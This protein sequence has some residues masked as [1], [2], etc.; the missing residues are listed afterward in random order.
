[1]S[2]IGLVELT[3]GADKGGTQPMAETFRLRKSD[4]TWVVRTGGAVIAESRNALEL[5]EGSYPVVIYFPRDDVAMAFLEPTE[6]KTT[7]PDIGAASYFTVTSP[8][9][10]LVDAAWSYDAPTEGAAEI[11]GHIAFDTDRVT[12][13]Q[14]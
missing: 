8:G 13:E 7:N 6:T 4:A 9:E 5:S 14:L 1:M 3:H 10:A 2:E 12:V 11:A